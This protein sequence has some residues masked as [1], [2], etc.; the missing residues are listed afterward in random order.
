MTWREHALCRD[1]PKEV[2][3]PDSD[4]SS[5]VKAAKAIC[6]ICPVRP[7]C[8]QYGLKHEKHGMWGGFTQKELN[9]KRTAQG[10]LVKE[11]TLPI[12]ELHIRREENKKCLSN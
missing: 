3:F 6:L 2:F 5:N 1:L 7:N 8:E 4:A 11:V 9:K 10:I 12:V